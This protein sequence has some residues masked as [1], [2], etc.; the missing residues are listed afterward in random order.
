MN[1]TKELIKCVIECDSDGAI[2][3]LESGD[4][5]ISIIDDIGLLKKP[6]PL[7]WIILCNKILLANDN[8]NEKYFKPVI[9]PART[10]NEILE[11]YFEKNGLMRG[12]SVDFSLFPDERGHFDGW[13]FEEMLDGSEEKLVSLG[14]DLDECK[15]C[16]A[17]LVGDIEEIENQIAKGTNPNVWISGDFT[18]D[19]TWENDGCSYNALVACNTFYCD[20]FDVY[21]LR[22]IYEQPY[23]SAEEI[24]K[25]QP[26]AELI[27]AAFYQDLEN[28]L[29]PLAR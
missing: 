20:V 27:E 23:Q 29:K 28:R 15:L 3:I 14:Y 12:H 9:I 21:S 1:K 13:D 5:N 19:K 2:A 6:F 7:S 24:V 16:Y 8:W 18:P 4:F 26:F 17:V 10:R 25:Y 11:K 22:G